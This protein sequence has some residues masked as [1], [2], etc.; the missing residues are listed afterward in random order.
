MR[1]EK[2]CSMKNTRRMPAVDGTYP[3]ENLTVACVR[4]HAPLHQNFRVLLPHFPAKITG[5][6]YT[7]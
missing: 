1:L 3:K 5:S 2:K 4:A 7:N 6:D